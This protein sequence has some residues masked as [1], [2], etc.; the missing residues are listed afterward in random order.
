MI[1]RIVH[2]SDDIILV[3][4]LL[5]L[6]YRGGWFSSFMGLNGFDPL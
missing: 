5:F 6:V 2:N 1:A 3:V 4:F